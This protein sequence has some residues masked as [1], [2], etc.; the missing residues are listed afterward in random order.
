MSFWDPSKRDSFLNDLLLLGSSV[1]EDLDLF[2][3]LDLTFLLELPSVVE[4]NVSLSFFTPS[5]EKVDMLADG[6]EFEGFS[7][8]FTDLF[9]YY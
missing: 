6:F 7:F 4:I 2:K 3:L 8:R 5:S 9:V 1:G